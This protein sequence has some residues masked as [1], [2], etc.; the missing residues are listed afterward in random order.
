MLTLVKQ[1]AEE[2]SRK[3]GLT[4]HLGFLERAW[5]AEIGELNRVARLVA[6]ERSALVVEVDSSPAMQ[7]ISLRRRE[8]VRRINRHF[9]EAVIQHIH[10]RMK[11]DGD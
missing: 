11:T 7:E 1:K 6:I 2:V 10:V 8:L 4:D 3:L 9:P 5:D